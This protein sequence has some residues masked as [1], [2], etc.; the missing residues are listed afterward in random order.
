MS[1][2]ITKT[3]VITTKQRA[4]KNHNRSLRRRQKRML[5][6]DLVSDLA[7]VQDRIDKANSPHEL[8]AM[9]NLHA[10][11]YNSYCELMDSEV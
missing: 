2:R 5:L 4:N 6:D 7:I 10:I 3:T 8:K 9:E 1:I 11:L